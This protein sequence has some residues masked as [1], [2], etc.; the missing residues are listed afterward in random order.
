MENSAGPFSFS[1]TRAICDAFDD[2]WAFLQETETGT[3]PA[4]TPRQGSAAVATSPEG[5]RSPRSGPARLAEHK[6]A[7]CPVPFQ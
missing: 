1:K 6:I 2:A 7:T 3:V 4:I 5:H